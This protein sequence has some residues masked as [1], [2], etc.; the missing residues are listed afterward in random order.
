M[1][2]KILLSLGIL[3]IFASN[4]PAQ[5]IPKNRSLYTKNDSSLVLINRHKLNQQ[6]N[7]ATKTRIG[8]KS[9]TALIADTSL[10]PYLPFVNIDISN[11]PSP[12]Y[13]FLSPSPYLEIVDN[14]GTPIFYQYA[15]GELYDFDLQP[16]GELT[17]FIYPTNCYGLDSSFNPVRSFNTT[18]GYAVDVH[19]LRVLKDGSYYIFGKKIITI[20]MSKIVPGGNTN[21]QIIDGV[22]QGFDQSGNLIFEWGGLNHYNILD[23]DQGIDLTQQTIDF[24]HFNSVEIDTDGNLLISARNLDE[25][26]KVD[27]KTGNII[28][29][30]GG[31]HNQ[32]TFIND[33]LGFS[34]QHDIRRFSNGDISIFDNGDYHPV[35]VSSAVE[36][37]LDEMNKTATLMHRYYHN[38]IYT[39]TEGSVEELPNGN[40]LISWGQNWDPIL[41]EVTPVDSIAFDLSYQDYFDTYRAFKYQW[42]TNL[43]TTNTDS[44]NFG[45]V[46]TGNSMIKQFTVFN[47]HNSAVTINEFYCSDPSFTT[48]IKV[49]V[50]IES[51]DSLIVPVTFN[52]AQEGNFKATFNVRNTGVYNEEQ[53]MIARQVILSGT[54]YDISQVNSGTITPRQFE[55]SQNYPNPYNPTTTI[56]YSIDKPGIV[57]LSVYDIRGSK[58]TTIV[59][60]NKPAGNYSV[61]FIASSLPS[62]IYFYKLE[63]GQYSQIKKMIL[64]K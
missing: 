20:D 5:N 37:K 23:V 40:R 18:D 25:I 53:Q 28:W 4:R 10:P 55:L 32:F 8:S 14:D 16:D 26:T 34:N 61:N 63:A 60:E 48:N 22:L 49:P 29:R 62:G 52:P 9:T 6:N 24:E 7:A 64:L 11:N 21:A 42:K 31:K 57:K 51:K 15:G 19:D 43:F 17:F 36:Y 54:T 2:N 13:Y 45:K 56:N 58:I 41:S 1:I 39:S 59:N 50:T 30:L 46:T 38:N 3:L 47:P 44:L 35:Q 12:G 33:P 27:R